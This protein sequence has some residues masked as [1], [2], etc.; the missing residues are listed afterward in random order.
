MRRA[1]IWLAAA[2]ACAVPAHALEMTR[3]ETVTLKNGVRLVMAPDQKAKSVDVAVWYDAGSRHDP[4][5]RTGVAHLF[6][7]LMF[8]GSS[9]V[10]DGEHGRLVRNEGGSSGA[11]ATHDF[12]SFYETLPPDAVELAFRLEADRMSGL[13]LTDQVLDQERRLVADERERRATPISLALERAYALAFPNHPYGI[14]VYGRPADLSKITLKELR[15]FYRARYGPSRALVTVVGSFSRD[16]VVSLARKYLE[17]IKGPSVKAPSLPADK[18]QTAERRAVT[19]AQVPL[20]VMMAAWRMPPR[21]HA[22]WAPLSLLA[23]VLT[24]ANDAPLAARLI[25]TPPLAY[26]VQ[27]DL[28][29]RRE[30]SLFYLA[31][32]VA[33]NADSTDVERALFSELERLGREPVTEGDL[34]R[35]KRQAETTIG[36]GLQTTRSRAQAIGSGCMLTGDT[37]DLDRLLDRVR[38]TKA[39]DLQRV[40]A[41]L[42]AARRNVVWL[43]P[44]ADSGPGRSSGGRP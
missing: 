39:A 15:D 40:A 26:S 36:F 41:Q 1:G 28:D 21:G 12:M 27:G 29:S 17:P 2:L 18:P 35:A 4:A 31:L 32:A 20:R 7:H 10:G 25:G 14:S 8:R 19:H 5:G 13:T 38:A 3:A 44:V 22:D 24:R 33:P 34:E 30:A 37:Q 9:H 23:S 6:E 11:Y 43:L 16:D 42:T